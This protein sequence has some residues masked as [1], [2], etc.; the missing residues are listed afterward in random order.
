MNRS[1]FI[2]IYRELIDENPLAVRAVLKILEVNFTTEV[3]TLAVTCEDKPRLLVN[4]DFVATHCRSEEHVKAI[5]CHEFLHVLLR[6]TERFSEVTPAMNIALDAVINAFIHRELGPEYSSFM[7]EFY[8]DARGACQLLRPQTE[9]DL[10]S[11]KRYPQHWQLKRKEFLRLWS[12]LYDGRLVV[13]DIHEWVLDLYENGGLEATVFIGSHDG[14]GGSFAESRA[15]IPP[16]LAKA[17]QRSL[18][19]LDVPGVGQSPDYSAAQWS[20]G[21]L[22]VSAAEVAVERWKRETYKVLERLLRPD[23]RSERDGSKER[24]THLPVLSVSDRRAV[25][26]ASWSPLIPE[27]CWPSVT[28]GSSGSAHVYLDVS[29]SMYDEMPVLITLLSRLGRRVRRPLWAFSNEVFP[30]RIKD[31]KLIAPSTGGTRLACVLEHVAAE[32]PPTALVVTDGYI[33]EIAPS[34]LHRTAATKLHAIVTR[35]GD[36]SVLRQA[37]ISYTQLGRFPND[38]SE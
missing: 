24:E 22:A 17:I 12:N 31:G 3:E 11:W 5:L 2:D 37:G 14:A 6:H 10:E 33:E 13:D 19:K 25:L 34:L 9:K 16:V 27:A 26:R 29:G 4:L 1:E 32:C 30:A 35:S 23:P 21:Q 36:S 8:A 20:Y 7:S 15:T 18:R 28:S 38:S